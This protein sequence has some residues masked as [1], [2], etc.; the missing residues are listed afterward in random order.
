MNTTIT[1]TPLDVEVAQAEAQLASLEQ[2]LSRA[3]RSGRDLNA[4]ADAVGQ[5]QAQLDALKARRDR[6]RILSKLK[7]Q[8]DRKAAGAQQTHEAAAKKNAAAV[9][10]ELAALDASAQEV[11]GSV[12]EAVQA[13]RAAVNQA[14]VH[15][16]MVKGAAGRLT[17]LGLPLTDDYQAYDTGGSAVGGKAVVKGDGR[18]FG[19]IDGIQLQALL[20]F[21]SGE[22]QRAEFHAQGAERSMFRQSVDRA[23]V[24]RIL[25][26]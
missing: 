18:V 10:R 24:T 26:E 12:A 16:E 21:I 14:R 2:E 22:V 15:S 3:A 1:T 4:H 23:I 13:L 7:E 19:T 5:A 20:K 25:G 9:K 8:E 6:A 11:A 17:G